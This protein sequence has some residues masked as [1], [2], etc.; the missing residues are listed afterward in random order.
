MTLVHH[1]AVVTTDVEESLRFWR[2]GLG[3]AVLLDAPFEGDWPTLLQASGTRLRSLFLGDPSTPA[4]GIIELVELPAGVGP[5][6]AETPPAQGFLLVSLLVDLDAALDRLASLDLGG[7]PRRITA[8]GSVGM[9]TV[10]DPNGVLVEL[11]DGGA[12]RL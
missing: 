12:A 11:I 5:R 7:E 10:R 3:L 1:T 2:D 8:Y 6:P 4:A 9:A